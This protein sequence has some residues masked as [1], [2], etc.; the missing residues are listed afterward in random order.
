MNNTDVANLLDEIGDLLEIQGESLFRTQAYHR[1]AQVIR[2]LPQDINQIANAGELTQISGV[3][4][5]IAQ[6]LEELLS[7][8]RMS[9]YEELKAKTPSSLVELMHVPGLGPKKAKLVFEELE[10]ANV[11]ELLKAAK[12][13]RLKDLPGMGAKTEE[14]ILRG[15]SQYQQQ[16]QRLL[17]SQALPTAERIVE[18]LQGNKEVK[19][20]SPAG[21][22]RRWKETIGD[23]DILAATD[24]PTKVAELFCTLPDV[25][26]I[27]AQGST[28]CSVILSSGLQVDL[29]LVKPE[30]FG[31][32]LQYF[33]GSK[34]HNIH[35][36]EIAKKR[37]LKLSE[38]GIF[39]VKDNL[40][41]GGATEEEV[42]KNLG[43]PYIEAVL[44]EDKGEIEAAQEGRLPHLITSADV[45]GDLH[46]H[47]KESD[48]QSSLEEMAEFA[49]KLGYQYLAISDHAEKLKVARGLTIERLEKQ[50]AK[51]K[52][53]NKNWDDLTL[54][55][56]TELNIDNEGNVDYPDDV[57]AQFDVVTASIHSGFGQEKSQITARTVTA[58][59]NP[60]IDIIGHPTGRI[61]GRR[62]PFQIDLP[63]VFEAA[64]KSNT[65]LELNAFP[66]RLDLNDDQLREAKRTGVKF[67]INTD[68]HHVGQLNYLRYGIATAQ[69]AWLTAEDVV[70]TYPLEKLQKFLT[71]R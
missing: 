31:A 50:W 46:A 8:G 12:E 51:I 2:S 28:K 71:K 11:K 56:S 52:E 49:R 66:D 61:L 45:K 18:Q 20:I 40:F 53:L 10:I 23:I 14:N 42:Y 57:L 3:G 43:L 30:Q 35:L 41:L 16:T 6:R 47:T 36:R 58:I 15:I 13:H 48:G 19:A 67:A 21:S 60:H 54:L 65:A 68:A 55:T 7:T 32:A 26:H 33:T 70:N 39:R 37:G 29:R 1:A 63:A 22:L 25:V 59:N 38:Y 24:D 5:G 44:R 69:R 27:L 9:Y 64:A 62:A 34:A 17:L 4:K